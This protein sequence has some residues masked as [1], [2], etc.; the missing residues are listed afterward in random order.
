MV[1]LIP[2]KFGVKQ[3]LMDSN[4]IGQLTWLKIKVIEDKELKAKITEQAGH[5]SGYGSLLEIQ[6]WR[7]REVSTNE[8]I[9]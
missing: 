9:H 2:W 6:D 5:L 8:N 3:D 7:L 4:E 1:N